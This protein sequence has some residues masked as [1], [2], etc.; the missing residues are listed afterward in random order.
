MNPTL[1]NKNVNSI[2]WELYQTPKFLTGGFLHQMYSLF[3]DTWKIIYDSN[4][5]RLEWLDYNLRRASGT[6]CSPSEN[7]LWCFGSGTGPPEASLLPRC[8]R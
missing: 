1:L 4:N 5:A 6:G 8:R 3:T 2:L 7:F